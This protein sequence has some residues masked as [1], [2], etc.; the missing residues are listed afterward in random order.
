MMEK[1]KN[2]REAMEQSPYEFL[3]HFHS[4]QGTPYQ[5]TQFRSAHEQA[6][7]EG[8]GLADGVNFCT[9]EHRH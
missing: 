1:L 9:V 7:W 4:I 3:W 8:S 2:N 6:A 5:Q